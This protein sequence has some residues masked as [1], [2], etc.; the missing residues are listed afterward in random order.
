MIKSWILSLHTMML[1]R[2]CSISE[3]NWNEPTEWEI[4]V[5]PTPNKLCIWVHCSLAQGKALQY[6]YCLSQPFSYKHLVPPAGQPAC[7]IS[8]WLFLIV[9]PGLQIIACIKDWELTFPLLSFWR[10]DSNRGNPEII[11]PTLPALKSFK[12]LISCRQDRTRMGT[13]TH[14]DLAGICAVRDLNS[15]QA[16]TPSPAQH[17]PCSGRFGEKLSLN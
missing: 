10:A 16:R 6:I 13:T 8:L 14:R 15:A 3:P 4:H 2:G 17:P 11:L 5:F 12:V 7:L 1:Q 9:A